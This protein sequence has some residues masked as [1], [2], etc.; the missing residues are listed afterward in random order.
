MRSLLPLVFQHLLHL[1][2]DV[3]ILLNNGVG[4]GLELLSESIR[5]TSLLGNV[6]HEV[7]KDALELLAQRAV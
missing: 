6:L 2:R 3:G 5:F 4:S 1:I 7:L